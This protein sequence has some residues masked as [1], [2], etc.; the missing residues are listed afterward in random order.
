MKKDKK[1]K[2]KLSKL[3]I[4][5]QNIAFVEKMIESNKKCHTLN[6]EQ[7]ALIK[8]Y[9]KDIENYKNIS[10]TKSETI[11]DLQATLTKEKASALFSKKATEKE[12]LKNYYALL[13]V[14]KKISNADYFRLV[15]TQT[16]PIKYLE[17]DLV[18]SQREPLSKR[19]RVCNSLKNFFLD[20]LYF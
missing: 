19:K 16:M 2:K 4:D 5:L 12:I 18:P 17:A 15:E 3:T 9:E 13:L 11:R 1:K 14:H 20:A 8:K 6:D 7:A 10:M